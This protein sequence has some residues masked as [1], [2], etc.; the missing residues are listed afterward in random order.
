MNVNRRLNIYFLIPLIVIFSL[1]SCIG[2]RVATE[3][4]NKNIR[5]IIKDANF[6]YSNF[7][8]D[9]IVEKSEDK[10][11]LI[12]TIK[13]R[14]EEE[15]DFNSVLVNISKDKITFY[16]EIEY[17]LILSQSKGNL[18]Y[19]GSFITSKDIDEVLNA[20]IIKTLISSTE[21]VD[22]I[23]LNGSRLKVSTVTKDIF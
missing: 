5:K 1:V 4:D 9:S 6:L 7:F 16:R 17:K 15:Y 11:E 20:D 8:D 22:R 13:L 21:K 23:V 14:A 19:S 3:E 2:G 18:E 10:N 12:Y